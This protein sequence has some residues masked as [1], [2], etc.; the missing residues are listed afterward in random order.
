M[1]H[2]PFSTIFHH[3]HFHCAVNC[4][5]ASRTPNRNRHHERPSGGGSVPG[6]P[7]FR[8]LGHPKGRTESP[9]LVQTS[10]DFDESKDSG[11]EKTGRPVVRLLSHGLWSSS[12]KLSPALK[13]LGS[14][15]RSL[16]DGRAESHYSHH[17]PSPGRARSRGQ[18]MTLG[19]RIADSMAYV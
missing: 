17:G 3:S 16:S 11:G 7:N 12:T 5:L 10:Q 13:S 18:E 15:G 9:R 14:R 4:S 2:V 19:I 1:H 6:S 8:P